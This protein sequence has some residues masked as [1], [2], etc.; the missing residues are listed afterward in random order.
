MDWLTT[1]YLI[2][3]WVFIAVDAALVCVLA[4]SLMKGWE[5]RPKLLQQD[6][7]AEKKAL[8]LGT[9][10]LKERWDEILQKIDGTPESMKLALI[11]ADNLA[12]GLLKDM[13]LEGEHMADRLE[14]LTRDD[15][16]TLDRLWRAHKVRNQL[17]HEPGFAL[18]KDQAGQALEDYEAFFKEAEAI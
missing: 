3:M 7:K 8:T 12:D 5:F 11:E 13:R 16:S 14:Q 15:F 9:A 18:S 10:L 1:L 6:E 4:L 17:V 2:V